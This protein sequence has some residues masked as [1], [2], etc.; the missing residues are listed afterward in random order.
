M[1]SII[2]AAQW[3]PRGFAA[4]FPQ[5]YTLDESEFERIAELAKLQ[6]DDAEDDL[7]EAEEEAENENKVSN[8][9]NPEGDHEME[10]D[11][12]KKSRK[13]TTQIECANMLL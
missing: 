13:K 1:S 11:G 10:V 12:G 8:G 5:K 7:K 9:S 3:V 6:L 4:P 2:T